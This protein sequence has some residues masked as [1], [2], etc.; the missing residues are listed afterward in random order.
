MKKRS[1]DYY[2]KFIREDIWHVKMSSL[3]PPKRFWIYFLRIFSVTQ[4]I[5]Y[6]TKLQQGAATLTYYTLLGL[7]PMIVILLGVARGFSQENIVVE[8]LF[9]KFGTQQEVISK[10]IDIAKNALS[11][12]NTGLVATVGL[13]ILLWS[14][15]RILKNLEISLNDIFDVHKSRSLIRQFSD[16]LAMIL[17][18]PILFIVSNTLGFIVS[19]KIAALSKES[20]FLTEIHPIL[21]VFYN[22]LSFF[23]TSS[24]FTF[25]YIFMPNTKVR[26]LPALYAGFIASFVYQIV[27]IA[28]IA[29]QIR[30]TQHNAIYGTFAAIPLFLM[31]T[32]LSWV[33]LLL[34]AKVA[35][36]FQNIEAYE[37]ISEDFKLSQRLEK[38]LSLRIVKYCVEKFLKRKPAPSVIEISK[39]L[40]IP[41]FIT[42]QIINNL[43]EIKLI[44]EVK[45]DEEEFGYYPAIDPSSLTIKRIIDMI[46]F[47]GE[48]THIS[49]SPD[50]ISIIES[51]EEFDRLIEQSDANLLIK[52]I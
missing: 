25:I 14:V 9:Q 13:I 45:K 40:A 44:S 20:A 48:Q 15:I 49:I 52:D 31:W 21:F 1:E 33:I 6:T 23:L 37:L 5:F 41:L 28:Y 11:Q 19:A 26:F 24:L 3:S 43:K 12:L 16:Y 38:I 50:Y 42:Q 39:Q 29:I 46:E 32:H 27:Q 18:S 17:F 7:V 51:L 8:A 36:A 10:I 30:V 47:K 22:L 35:F 4:K 34:G 2:F